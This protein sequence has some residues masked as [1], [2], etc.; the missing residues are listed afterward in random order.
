MILQRVKN[1]SLKFLSDSPIKPR[2]LWRGYSLLQ[3]VY[4]NFEICLTLLTFRFKTY[5]KS[6]NRKNLMATKEDIVRKINEIDS[7]K[8]LKKTAYHLSYDISV[9]LSEEIEEL[10]V[11]SHLF[12]AGMERCVLRVLNSLIKQ[13]QPVVIFPDSIPGFTMMIF[14]KSEPI[15]INETKINRNPTQELQ[16]IQILDSVISKFFQKNQQRVLL[17]ENKDL[18]FAMFPVADT[19]KYLKEMDLYITF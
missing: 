7:F 16:E 3:W 14:R 11:Y 5:I 6:E 12:K 1:L 13:P 19:K 2:P 17:I 8:D 9:F 10:N 4:F 15:E 18:L